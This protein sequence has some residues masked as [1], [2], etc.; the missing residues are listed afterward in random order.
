MKELRIAVCVFLTVVMLSACIYR[1]MIP[2]H[3]AYLVDSGGRTIGVLET[4]TSLEVAMR[5]LMPNQVYD[6]ELRAGDQQVSFARQTTDRHG[7]IDPFHLLYHGGVVGCSLRSG[8]AKKLPPFLFRNFEEAAAVLEGRTLTLTVTPVPSP[9]A[10]LFYRDR[11]AA[12]VHLEI[13][14]R[15][16]RE[17]MVYASDSKGCLV[18]SA[19]V[20]SRDLYV[21]GQNFKPEEIIEVAVVPNQRDW[22]V[23]DLIND[24]TGVSGAAA[25]ERVRTDEKGRFTVRVWQKDLQ[26]RGAYDFVVRR[27]HGEDALKIDGQV[28]VPALRRIQKNDII[29]YASDTAYLLFLR[30]PPGGPL[31]DIAGRPLSGSPYFQFADSFTTTNDPVWGAVDPTYVPT[32]HPGGRYAAYYVVAHRDVAGWDPLMGGST[33]LSDVSG[34]PE[35][36]PIKAGCINGTDVRIW[37]NPTIGE[38]DV[39][40][41]FGSTPAETQTQFTD[42]FNYDSGLDFL[43]GADQ[44]GFRV[45][46]DP[47]EI[48]TPPD[49]GTYYIGEASYSFDNLFSTFGSASNVDLRAVV[50]YPAT[51]AGMNRPVA[52]GQHPLFV[53]EHGNH[54]HC[55]VV[56]DGR[57]FYVALRE[58]YQSG[59]PFT[60]YSH[61]A[62]PD[63]EVNHQGYMHLLEA[64]A[65]HGIIAISIDAYD[66]TGSVPSW[67][68]ER[69]DLILKHLEFWSHLNDPTTFPTYTDPLGGI[70]QNHVDMLKISVSGHSRGGE[71]SVAAYMR[72][73]SSSNPFV[74][75]S[76]S[77]IAPVDNLG[78]VLPD[79]PYFV[80]LPAADGDVSS[81]SGAR[82]FD[83]AGGTSDQTVKSGIHVYGASH[84]FFNT[85]WADDWDD[86]WSPRDD[87]ISK[88]NQQ[89]IGEVYL[90]AF[91]RAH[92]LGEPVYEDMLRGRLIFPSTSGYK[93]H[94]FR[95]E[96]S[97][98]KLESGTI[99][100]TPSGGATAVTV[101]NPSVHQ[102]QAAR[103]G[104]STST[105]RYTFSVPASQRNASG[106]EVLSFRVAQTNNTVNPHT[107]Q[108]F[109]VKLIG[110]GKERAIYTG[111]FN[112]I[113][114]P[115]DRKNDDSLGHVTGDAI[116]HNVMTTVRIPL[117]SFI[118][119]RSGV[120]LDNIDTV[121]FMFT[122]PAQGEIYVDDVE[123]S[124]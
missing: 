3:G 88:E 10:A 70:F 84:N 50:R 81:L 85:V 17:A 96:K 46:N 122:N 93:I 11:P 38:Y 44:I 33:A 45:V 97:H 63:R 31:M 37:N 86:S 83:R 69:G 66:L 74:I 2:K 24:V 48:E 41:N 78:Y 39:V 32:T 21:S 53:I 23:D 55:K 104:W 7:N 34:G 100:G 91:A 49:P 4:G 28:K 77:S 15:A 68:E 67:I 99:K 89:K 8:T 60:A 103:I 119:N 102:T 108:E 92:L 59:T 18:N 9:T 1:P 30:Y 58:Y 72:N 115:Y 13:P 95:H 123:F 51:S 98:S 76:V 20:G 124:R 42:D 75:G 101:T 54:A 16:R 14:V 36:M 82:I 19:E 118:V 90:S 121:D 87:Y 94:H 47:Y 105:G 43:D 62:C 109:Q 111:R 26:V 52:P 57:D 107:G 27:L 79:V 61:D 12:K 65:S 64:L 110:G 40:V 117:Q 112:A 6:V 29:A 113:P 114:K 106:F 80:I 116:D 120:T 71:A 56:Q 35:I 25:P 22:F 5:G 73:L